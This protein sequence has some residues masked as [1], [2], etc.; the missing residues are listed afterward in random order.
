MLVVKSLLH[1]QR[2]YLKHTKHS[3]PQQRSRETMTGGFV[4]SGAQ[5]R[6]TFLL[7]RDAESWSRAGVKSLA[8]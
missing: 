6:E 4:M 8:T 5:E 1:S 7:A 3:P 2:R